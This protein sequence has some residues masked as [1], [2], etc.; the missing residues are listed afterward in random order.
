MP[1]EKEAWHYFKRGPPALFLFLSSRSRC[2]FASG[3]RPGSGS[4]RAQIA[5]ST[6]IQRVRREKVSRNK[7]GAIFAS[8]FSLSLSFLLA[9]KPRVVVIS[10]LARAKIKRLS[11]SSSSVKHPS[12]T[13]DR[14]G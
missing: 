2:R 14:V 12:G 7:R 1:S 3:F 6:T 9:N 10:K 13:K 4:P 5:P 11:P 8:Q